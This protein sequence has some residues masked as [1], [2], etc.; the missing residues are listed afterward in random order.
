M[1]TAGS[2]VVT[3][4]SFVVTPADYASRQLMVFQ[5]GAIRFGAYCWTVHFQSA[6]GGPIGLVNNVG[7][8]PQYLGIALATPAAGRDVRLKCHPIGSVR[9]TRQISKT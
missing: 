1:T 7:I 5:L 4:G 2:F 8:H 9:H 6:D 3:A